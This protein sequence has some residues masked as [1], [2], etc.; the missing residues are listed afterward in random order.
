MA[1]IEFSNPYGSM[2]L[3]TQKPEYIQGE[4]IEGEISLKLKKKF[5]GNE[6]HLLIQ[7]MEKTDFSITRKTKKGYRTSHYSDS[8]E[9]CNIKAP[10]SSESLDI[11]NYTFPFAFKLD[12]DLPPSFNTGYPSMS[13]GSV[14]Y[15]LSANYVSGDKSVSNLEG[16]FILLLRNKYVDPQDLDDP[17][18]EDTILKNIKLCGCCPRGS[19]S[20]KYSFSK[21]IYTITED[22]P[23]GIELDNQKSKDDVEEL[24]CKVY[25]RIR[26]KARGMLGGSKCLDV[27]C[28]TK[29]FP[30]K[31]GAGCMGCHAQVTGLS[32]GYTCHPVTEPAMSGVLITCWYEVV[33]TPL[34]KDVACLCCRDG[35]V[36]EFHIHPTPRSVTRGGGIL[37]ANLTRDVK[38]VDHAIDGLFLGEEEE[39]E[40]DDE[41]TYVSINVRKQSE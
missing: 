12:D 17:P 16:K 8:Y 26:I 14:E 41:K 39:E 32:I 21:R 30:Y 3:Q 13:H 22:I 1:D 33:A 37:P 34:Y 24:E 5:P 2:S 25:Q 40:D 9:L 15:S 31:V 29:T 35:P 10:I 19:G 18:V 36:V 20:L 28:S 6:L 23:F 7:G 4:N 11:G 38:E 27:A